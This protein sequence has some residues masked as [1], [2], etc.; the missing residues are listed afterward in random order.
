[1]HPPLPVMHVYSRAAPAYDDRVGQMSG[2]L[3]VAAEYYEC[4]AFITS[5][6]GATFVFEATM[7]MAEGDKASKWVLAG[8][9][10]MMSEE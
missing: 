7:K 9:A 2:G 10:L 8:V 5:D 3:R 6:R 1:L 4:P